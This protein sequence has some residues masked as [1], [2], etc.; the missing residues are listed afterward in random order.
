MNVEV[1][2]L[3]Y[4]RSDHALAVIDSLVENRVE[5]VRA[6][7]DR[8]DDPAVAK[9]QERLLAELGRIDSIA[10]DLHLHEKRLGLARSV[11]FAL[12][13]TFEKADAAILLEDDCVMRPGAMT[14]FREGLEALRHDRRVRSLCGYLFPCPFIRSDAEPLLLRRFC[15]WGWATWR[16]R[17]RDYDPDLAR[18][19]A[20]LGKSN[21]RLEELAADLAALCRAPEYL[22]GRVDIW[23]LSW[24]LEHYATGTFSVYPC[25][26][27]IENIGFDGSG[28]NCAPTADFVTSGG[29]A[30]RAWSFEH[31]FHCVENEVLV[32]DFMSRHGLK[33]YPR[34]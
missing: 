23:S 6:Y 27:L 22:E 13:D 33:T 7:V 19:V 16:D 31:L 24:V 9:R 12:E 8:P 32:D 18:V 21:V 26:S 30:Q 25:D 11:R 3:L 28:K 4:D 10:I 5:R 15:T 20:R 2:L 34:T 14:F 29:R 1:V 17:W